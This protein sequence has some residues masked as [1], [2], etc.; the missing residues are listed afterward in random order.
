MVCCLIRCVLFTLSIAGDNFHFVDASE[1]VH[2]SEFYIVQHQ[3]P[4]VVTETVG[5]QF[6]CLECDTS[7]DLCV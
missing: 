2:F 7:F 5:V 6:G 1:F 4:H 3:C